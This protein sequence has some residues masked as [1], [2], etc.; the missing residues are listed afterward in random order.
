MEEILAQPATLSMCNLGAPD[1][2][3][4]P[5]VGWPLS[6]LRS[7]FRNVVTLDGLGAQRRSDGGLRGMRSPLNPQIGS[8]YW[9]FIELSKH[10]VI[11]VTDANYAQDTR[12]EWPVESS[13]KIRIVFNGVL[14]GDRGETLLR[15]PS[16]Y[17]AVCGPSGTV[18]YTVAAGPLQMV[19][20]HCQPSM[21]TEALGLSPEQCPSPMAKL[22]DED[23]RSEGSKLRVGPETF[24]AAN[25]LLRSG[26]LYAGALQRVF[27]ETKCREI[28]VSIL[29]QLEQDLTPAA[30]DPH[31][32]VRVIG[33]VHEAR[34]IL[35]D[36]FEKP[37]AV[38]KL[39]RLVGLNQTCLRHAFKAVF[40]VTLFGFVARCRME[41]AIELLLS[42]EM[43]IS[44]VSYAV[45]YDYPANF[46]H[47][48]KRHFGYAPSEARRRTT[49]A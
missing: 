42:S 7:Y 32:P 28:V 17:L 10:I 40:G 12:I 27:V 48:F 15:G 25:D 31:L 47:A 6:Q 2:V 35:L 20:L 18:G 8:G 22:L 26:S 49:P 11:S 44:E 41:R 38:P 5:V 3:C 23:C 34:D 43:S 29:R 14:M 46:T 33:R 45:G 1:V 24:R 30:A 21:I 36:H 16:A 4:E 19:V 9:D 39:S 37:P 13:F